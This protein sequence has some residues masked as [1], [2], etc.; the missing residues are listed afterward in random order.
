M[1]ARLE[2]TVLLSAKATADGIKDEGE[3]GAVAVVA[4][5]L[6]CMQVLGLI[7][8][9]MLRLSGILSGNIGFLWDTM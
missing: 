9:G 1:H 7:L 2:A 5:L 3:Q 8:F 6:R 4:M